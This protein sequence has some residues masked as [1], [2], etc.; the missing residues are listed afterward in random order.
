MKQQLQIFRERSDSFVHFN[1]RKQIR[2]VQW[3]TEKTDTVTYS[4]ENNQNILKE[5]KY[6][7]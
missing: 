3:K 2:V 5:E 6:E 1:R 4:K 7:I